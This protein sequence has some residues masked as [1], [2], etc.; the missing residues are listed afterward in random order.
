MA[1]TCAE[2]DIPICA[3]YPF[4]AGILTGQITSEASL[5]KGDVR[6]LFNSF[7]NENLE[8]TQSTVQKLQNYASQKN[9]TTAQ[10]LLTWIRTISARPDMPVIIPI[11]GAKAVQRVQENTD[12]KPLFSEQEMEELEELTKDA[13]IHGGLGRERK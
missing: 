4:G 10:L 5:L 11:P 1:K 8:A 2:L 3:Y 7:R 13:E 6:H 12:L 9:M